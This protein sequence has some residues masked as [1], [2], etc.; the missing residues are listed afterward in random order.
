MDFEDTQLIDYQTY[1]K[2]ENSV[3][4]FLSPSV[5]KVNFHVQYS[6]VITTLC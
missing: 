1:Q 5:S 3:N 2:G 4:I 6:A